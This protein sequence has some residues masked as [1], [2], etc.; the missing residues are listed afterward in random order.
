[1][2]ANPAQLFDT[3]Q[4]VGLPDSERRGF[5]GILDDRYQVWWTILAS[6]VTVAECREQI[7]D[8][9]LTDSIPDR[10]LHSAHRV[11]HCKAD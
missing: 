8:S 6:Q 9:T 1:M 11:E 10:L 7:G 4:R 2:Q 3:P 5:L